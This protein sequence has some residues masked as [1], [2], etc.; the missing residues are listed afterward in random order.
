MEVIFDILLFVIIFQIVGLL[1]FIFYG[2]KKLK[3]IIKLKIKGN[4][5]KNQLNKLT[6]QGKIKQIN[7]RRK[8]KPKNK[9]KKSNS[10]KNKNK[11][12]IK[13]TINNNNNKIKNQKELDDKSM[14][15]QSNRKKS[16]LENKKGN[17]NPF[18]LMNNKSN[19]NLKKNKSKNK[20]KKGK[21][22]KSYTKSKYP[23]N[24]NDYELNSLIYNLA[25]IYDKRTYFQYY[26]SLIKTQH[27][28]L[29]AI[30]PSNDYNS[31]IIKLCIFTFSF[32]QYY[33]VSALFFNE[34][35][36]HLIYMEE[37]AYNIIYQ[38]PQIFYSS[39]ISSVIN[40][41]IKYLS[42]SQKN[43]INTKNNQ[44]IKNNENKLKVLFEC[45]TIKFMLFFIISFIFLI[46]F[47]YYLA[48]FCAVYRNT[49]IYLLKDTLIS[50]GLSLLYPIFIYL[51]PG[52]FRI[53]AL[54]DKNK[55]KECLY[56]FSKFLQLI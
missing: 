56:N 21:V 49:Q 29:F 4:K 52:V 50:Y 24:L 33:T 30:I 19:Q 1:I 22:F 11:I 26:F 34:S 16:I 54:R 6:T 48:C 5:E 25:L 36:M 17:F 10:K 51:T 13:R 39:L 41:I 31:R 14:I 15:S 42:L 12:K 7:K 38:L 44:A 53:L 9:I 47:W 20:K 45:L 23:I 8:I 27:I 37:G 32:A 43:V 55:K 40:I 35:T 18:T 28:L 2:F 3:K 46:F